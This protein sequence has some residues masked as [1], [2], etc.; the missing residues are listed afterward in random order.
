MSMHLIKQKNILILCFFLAIS[1]L[2]FSQTVKLNSSDFYKEG[3]DANSHYFEFKLIGHVSNLSLENFKTKSLSFNFVLNITSTETPDG[4]DIKVLL[5]KKSE[6]V[7]HYYSNY[8]NNLSVSHLTVDEK[9][10]KTEDFYNY[11]ATKYSTT[12][13][14][15]H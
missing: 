6:S 12:E 13:S 7:P 3:I 5:D 2:S 14:A 1:G 10:I 4:Y 15:H 11:L 9:V 8:F